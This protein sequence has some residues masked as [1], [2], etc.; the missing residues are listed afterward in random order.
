MNQAEHLLTCAAEEG[1]EIAEEACRVALELSKVA[2][3]GLRFGLDDRNVLNPTGPTNRERL[4]DELNDLLGVAALMVD[5]G[6][7]PAVWMDHAKIEAKKAKVRKFMDHARG[8]GAL[9]DEVVV[10]AQCQKD[11]PESRRVHYF[12]VPFCSRRCI[13]DWDAARVG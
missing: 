13:D 9:E 1:V 8:T 10:C 7:L 6:V 3:K 12:N 11:H 5:A 4:I 2:H